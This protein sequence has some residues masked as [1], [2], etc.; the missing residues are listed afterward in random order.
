MCRNF[1]TNDRSAL[2]Q[3]LAF[4]SIKPFIREINA[5]GPVNVSFA[6]KMFVFYSSRQ[7][8]TRCLAVN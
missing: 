5:I 6:L 3:S 8:F 2:L 7:S 1:S 4:G